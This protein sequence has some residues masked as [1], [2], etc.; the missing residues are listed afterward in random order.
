MDGAREPARRLLVIADDLTGALDTGV[1]LARAGVGTV[2]VTRAGLAEALQGSEPAVVVDTESRHLAAAD[3]ATRVVESVLG[4]C[5]AGIDLF[6]KKTDST[7]RGNVGAELAALL[8]A[9]GGDE[10][11]FV[12]ALPKAGRITRHGMHLVNGVPLQE[13]T[14]GKDPRDPV[15]TSS[16]VDL[17][18]AQSDLPAIVVEIGAVP[19]PDGSARIIVFDAETD[20]DLREIADRLAAR[21]TVRLTAGCSGFA[22]E[23]PRMLALPSGDV[24]RP[25][26]QEPILILSASPHEM[27]T[28]QIRRAQ[29]EGIPTFHNPPVTAA[30]VAGLASVLHDSRIVAIQADRT[31][32]VGELARTILERTVVATLVVFG[33]DTA[34]AVLQALG[35]RGLRPLGEVCQGVVISEPAGGP[36]DSGLRLVTKAGGFGPQDLIGRIRATAREEA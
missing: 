5:A 18:A 12:P 7:L 28:A 9:A 36:G 8:S 29:S 19:P 30:A 25:T 10:L 22:Q 24:P 15:R 27:T 34:F 20:Q 2:V 35:I 23:L 16:V 4:A 31:A 3:A 13:S 32:E 33:G 14:F 1:Q 17:I 26:L 6:Y 21:G 11:F